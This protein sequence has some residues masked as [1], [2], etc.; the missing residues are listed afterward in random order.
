MSMIFFIKNNIV[1]NFSNTFKH[2]FKQQ[3][4]PL[5]RWSNKA[6]LFNQIVSNHDHCGDKVCGKTET[7]LNLKKEFRNSK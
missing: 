1:M 4:V 6:A 5:G 3:E 2:M 7:I